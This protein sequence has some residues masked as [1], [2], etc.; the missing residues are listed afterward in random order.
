MA[1]VTV[2]VRASPPQSTV[3]PAVYPMMTVSFMTTA[4]QT[5]RQP[6]AQQPLRVTTTVTASFKATAIVTLSP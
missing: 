2:T 1:M 6:A 3:T 5:A 4:L